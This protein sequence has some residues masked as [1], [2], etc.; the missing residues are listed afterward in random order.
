MWQDS[1]VSEGHAATIFR[2]KWCCDNGGSM[3]LQNAGMLPH[4]FMVSQLKYHDM[5]LYRRESY[6]SR[7]VVQFI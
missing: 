4:H 7:K 2:V 5:D 6:T 3:T 1:Y